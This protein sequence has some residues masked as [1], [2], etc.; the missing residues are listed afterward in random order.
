[1]HLKQ[2]GF[3]LVELIIIVIVLAILAAFAVEKFV[4]LRNDAE[5]SQAR[6]LRAAYQQSVDFS[7][8]RWLTL[9]GQGSQNDMPGFAGGQLDINL[10][11]YP[12]GIDKR[13]P[14][15]AP[16]N[17]GRRDKACVELWQTLLDTAET[18]SLN[19]DGS[20]Y[21]A[22][23]HEAPVNPDGITHCSYVLRSLGDDK[24]REQADHVIIYDSREGTVNF[25]QN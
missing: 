22:Y 3:T 17:I 6:A 14:M 1:M 8:S 4:S 21:Q 15:T 20:D 23:R 2:Q 10:Q 18:V 12:L 19:D 13:S 11:G 16:K 9:G 24:G 25:Q 5:I 7:H